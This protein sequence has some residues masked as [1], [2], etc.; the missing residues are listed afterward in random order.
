MLVF[1]NW[2]LLLIRQLNMA[3]H[4]T[5]PVPAH[6]GTQVD[7]PAQ[8]GTHV[9][10]PAQAGTK[11]DLPAHNPKGCAGRGPVNFIPRR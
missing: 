8:A 6:A 7:L 2:E 10:L 9:D 4:F 1:R 3:N 11:I 5:R